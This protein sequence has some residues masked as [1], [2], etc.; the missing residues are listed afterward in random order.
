MSFPLVLSPPCPLSP[1]HLSHVSHDGSLTSIQQDIFRKYPDRYTGIIP[2]LC[3]S[4]DELDEP[5]AKASL[6]WILGEY[7]DKIDNA[8]E[9]IGEFL[10]GYAE[11]SIQVSLRHSTTSLLEMLPL[12]TTA[13]DRN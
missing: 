6:I 3:A 11:E 12:S 2:T 7:A 10:V 9:L 5:D 8:A 4:L 1:L 13:W